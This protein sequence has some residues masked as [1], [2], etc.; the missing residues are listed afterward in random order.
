MAKNNSVDLLVRFN[1]GLKR[2]YG[3]KTRERKNSDAKDRS[4]DITCAFHLLRC[5]AIETFVFRRMDLQ[6]RVVG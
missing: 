3:S 1:S 5:S 4:F 2:D 6:F